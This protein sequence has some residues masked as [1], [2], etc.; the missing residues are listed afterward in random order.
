VVEGY[1]SHV[2]IEP[3]ER[4]NSDMLACSCMGS[5]LALAGQKFIKQ[6]EAQN[7]KGP[8]A[9]EIILLILII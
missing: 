2:C 1:H 8:K 7:V 5:S 9:N 4:E 3:F 6:K